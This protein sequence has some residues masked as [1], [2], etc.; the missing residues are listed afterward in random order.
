MLMTEEM[1]DNNTLWI[2]AETE[3]VVEPADEEG[4]RSSRDIGGGFNLPRQVLE[5][6]R[7]VKRDRLPIPAD[8][9]KA[10][11]QSM[12]TIIND[13]FDQASTHT[14]LQLSEVE[15]SVEI[16]AEG[17]VSLIGTGGSLGSKGGI[18]L[19]FVRSPEQ[20]VRSPEKA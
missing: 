4:R 1:T 7:M 19:K 20:A 13:L 16:N 17:K 2:V 9:V 3:I 15:L 8:Q 10:Q 12:V 5:P 6:E 11:M 18:K 14:G